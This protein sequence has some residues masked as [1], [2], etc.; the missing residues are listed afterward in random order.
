LLL[1]QRETHFMSFHVEIGYLNHFQQAVYF[2]LI[3]HRRIYLLGKSP[4]CSLAQSITDFIHGHIRLEYIK[5]IRDQDA[6][7]LHW[8]FEKHRYHQKD[9][10]STRLNSSHVSISYAVFCL[11]KKNKLMIQ[12]LFIILAI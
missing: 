6:R 11:K 12:Q 1:T 2:Q 5:H 10:K 8:L 4:V 3:L 9:R 7:Q